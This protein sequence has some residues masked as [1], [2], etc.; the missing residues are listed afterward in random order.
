[1]FNPHRNQYRR[2]I[3][4]FTFTIRR[5]REA[6]AN[7]FSAKL[8]A[9]PVYIRLNPEFERLVHS[10]MKILCQPMAPM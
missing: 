5:Q 9:D 6:V 4:T 3:T 7:G 1:M 2:K 10:F 8:A